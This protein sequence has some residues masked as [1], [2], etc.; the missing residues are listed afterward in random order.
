MNAAKFIPPSPGAEFLTVE[1]VTAAF[2]LCESHTY[3]LLKERK[4]QGVLDKSDPCSER[5]KRLF[6]A[7]SISSYLNKLRQ[8]QNPVAPCVTPNQ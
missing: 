8:D 1:G 3:R 5:G 4:I 7:P 6:Y 2:G